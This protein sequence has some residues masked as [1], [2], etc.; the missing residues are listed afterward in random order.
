MPNKLTHAETSMLMINNDLYPLE[1]YPGFHKPWL[2]IHI[3]C[4]QLTSPFYGNV[5]KGE[6]GCMPCGR[7]AQSINSRLNHNEAAEF[8]RSKGF[9]PQIPYPGSNT[10]WECIHTPCQRL[11]SPSYQNVRQGS[12]CNLCGYDSAGALLSSQN[13]ESAAIMIKNN[14]LPIVD[15]PGSKNPWLSIHIPCGRLTNPCLNNVQQRG[16][17][18]SKCSY[19]M[20]GKNLRLDSDEVL[21][22]MHSKNLE[23]QT[24]YLGGKRKWLCVHKECG[25]TISVTYQNIRKGNSGCKYCNPI[26][27]FDPNKS[28]FLYVVSDEDDLVR[29]VGISN[30]PN[31]RLRDHT[32]QGL[33]EVLYLSKEMHGS[34]VA[35]VERRWLDEV[36]L[37]GAKTVINR[38][39]PYSGRTESW[40]TSEYPYLPDDRY[41]AQ[42]FVDNRSNQ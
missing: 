4:G 31:N 33:T 10:P 38:K 42:S 35:Y 19:E 17:G 34:R 1:F 26:R 7:I 30:N 12:G 29:K 18:C 13:G 36:R 2:C 32:K 21:D 39:W 9:D 41:V 25:N 15:Y 6:S 8:M 24:N 20:R 37:A 40:Y 16:G 27:G 23:P 5:K 28:G 11:V 22:F 14:L 3:P